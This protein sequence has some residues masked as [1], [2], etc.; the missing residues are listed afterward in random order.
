MFIWAAFVAILTAVTATSVDDLKPVVRAAATIV[1]GTIVGRP[2]DLSVK[3]IR[4]FKGGTAP[5][6]GFSGSKTDFSGVFP[7][8]TRILFL[9]KKNQLIH[10]PLRPSLRFLDMVNAL[11]KGIQ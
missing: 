7:G 8:D 3:T 2:T 9:N 11:V 6:I 4:T 10:K 1:T 5:K